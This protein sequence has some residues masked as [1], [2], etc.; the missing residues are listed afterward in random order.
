MGV[1]DG[2]IPEVEEVIMAD[3]LGVVIDGGVVEEVAMVI[4]HG[5]GIV[6]YIMSISPMNILISTKIHVTVSGNIKQLSMPI[7]PKKM[8]PRF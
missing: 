3:I 1:T 4:G 6:L 5:G 8:P 2:A 7:Y